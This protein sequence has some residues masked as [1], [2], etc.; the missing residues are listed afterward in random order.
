MKDYIK[1]KFQK[2]LNNS[3]IG[4]GDEKRKRNK[5]AKARNEKATRLQANAK[6]VIAN[7]SQLQPPFASQVLLSSSKLKSMDLLSEG[8]IE[9]FF[10]Q[11]GERCDPLEAFYLNDVPVV[12]SS[13]TYEKTMDLQ[14]NK[15]YGCYMNYQG[16]V[17]NRLASYRNY[18]DETFPD[19]KPIELWA[20]ESTGTTFNDENDGSWVRS[21]RLGVLRDGMI[22]SPKSST[23]F[24][25]AA[26][27]ADIATSQFTAALAVNPWFYKKLDGN[28]DYNALTY[29]GTPNSPISYYYE[30]TYRTWHGFSNI[31]T[32]QFASKINGP[33]QA[34]TVGF[35]CERDYIYR[36]SA[37][38]GAGIVSDP[39]NVF[40]GRGYRTAPKY[41]HS[42]YG[43]DSFLSGSKQNFNVS[44]ESFYTNEYTVDR[45]VKFKGSASYVGGINETGAAQ[46]AYCN[47]ALWMPLT[48]Y[49]KSDS[50]IDDFINFVA[51]PIVFMPSMFNSFASTL[52]ISAAQHNPIQA[53]FD[54]D[55]PVVPNSFFDDNNSAHP[56]VKHSNTQFIGNSNKSLNYT[57]AHQAL[58]WGDSPRHLVGVMRGD[59]PMKSF[60]S[61][62]P[63]S[64]E[65]EGL[66]EPI[67]EAITGKVKSLPSQ[68]LPYPELGWDGSTTGYLV[69]NADG[70]RSPQNFEAKTGAGGVQ[71]KLKIRRYLHSQVQAETSS[72]YAVTG[73][74]RWRMYGGEVWW[75][76]SGYGTD[77]G[78]GFTV[79]TDTTTYETSAIDGITINSDGKLSTDANAFFLGASGYHAGKGIDYTYQKK[80]G[81]AVNN[82]QESGFGVLLDYGQLVMTPDHI[83]LIGTEPPQFTVIDRSGANVNPITGNFEK[84]YTLEYALGG[85][86]YETNSPVTFD[87]VMPKVTGFNGISKNVNESMC[88][89]T[90]VSAGK[91]PPTV[92]YSSTYSNGNRVYTRASS[93]SEND[94]KFFPWNITGS[95]VA[96]PHNLALTEKK[97]STFQ[98]TFMW[99][100]YLGENCEGMGGGE[101]SADP[102]IS[103]GID[104]HYTD[105][106]EEEDGSAGGGDLFLRDRYMDNVFVTNQLDSVKAQDKLDR[107]KLHGYDLF[108]GTSD[109][110]IQYVHVANPKASIPTGEMVGKNLQVKLTSRS[111][112]L[113]NYTN[114]SIA[115][116]LGTDRM[117][118]VF[119]GDVDQIGKDVSYNAPLTTRNITEFK[120]DKE[121]FGPL[122]YLKSGEDGANIKLQTEKNIDF[123]GVYHLPLIHNYLHDQNPSTFSRSNAST[124]SHPTNGQ[125]NLATGVVGLSGYLL[126][127]QMTLFGQSGYATTSSDIEITGGGTGHDKYVDYAGWDLTPA[128]DSDETNHNHVVHRQE[129]DSVIINFAIDALG[130][131]QAFEDDGLGAT[132]ETDR[133]SVN[134]EVEVGFQDVS[135]EIYTPT[136]QRI[137]YEGRVD[138]VYRVDSE[139]IILPK[140]STIVESF[141]GETISSVANKHKRY[142]IIRKLDYETLSARIR[143]SI[144][145]VGISEVI[146][147]AFTYPGSAVAKINVDARQFQEI[148]KRTYNVRLKKVLIPSNYY[149]LDTA[150]KD[151]R[152]VEKESDVGTRVIYDG[153]WNGNFKLGWTDNPAWILY[154]LLINNRY[155]LGSRLDDLED[156]DIFNLYKIG[157]YCDAVNEEG[158]YLGIQDGIGGLEPR[159]SCN[160]LFNESINAFD[161]LQEISSIFNGRAFWSNGSIDFYSDRPSLTSAYFN[162]GNVFD[163]V[164]NYEDTSTASHFNVVEVIFQDKNDDFKRKIETVEDEEGIRKNGKLVRRTTGRGTTSRGQARRLA[165]YILYS[166]KLEREIVSFQAGT[167]SLMLNVG[168]VME[169]QDELKGF[170][171]DY[172]KIV[173]TERLDGKNFIHIE[174]TINSGSIITDASTDF[175]TGNEANQG[176]Y[177]PITGYF[178]QTPTSKDDLYDHLKTGGNITEKRIDSLFATDGSEV[179]KSNLE[180]AT[181]SQAVRDAGGKSLHDFN[182][183]EIY[184]FPIKSV[185][186]GVLDENYNTDGTFERYTSNGFDSDDDSLHMNIP[187]ASMSV[188]TKDV[189]QITEETIPQPPTKTNGSDA[190]RAVEAKITSDGVGAV[191]QLA[192]FNQRGDAETYTSYLDNKDGIV[193][194]IYYVPASNPIVGN[195]WHIGAGNSPDAG[196]SSQ[197]D[198]KD[199]YSNTGIYISGDVWARGTLLYGEKFGGKDK[200]AGDGTSAGG[201]A[202]FLTVLNS[203]EL[204]NSTQRVLSTSEGQAYYISEYTLRGSGSPVCSSIKL[205]IDMA[206]TPID[207]LHLVKHVPTGAFAN[208]DLENKTKQQYRVLS[209]K[210]SENNLYDIVGTEYNSSKFEFID[211]SDENFQ[212]SDTTGFNIGIPEH[213]VNLPTEPTS[214]T[215]TE[216]HAPDGTFNL[217]FV[218]NGDLNGTEKK[219]LLSVVFPNGVRQDKKVLKGDSDGS[220]FVTVESI[221]GLI[222]FGTY[223]V[224]VKSIE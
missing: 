98:G 23:N 172:A 9:G 33:G 112:D 103:D 125:G 153:S 93:Y 64:E 205:E 201:A 83:T 59:I 89:E 206:N 183:S 55:N 77:Y 85:E 90:D 160:I 71:I 152:F 1:K 129:V 181:S 212:V 3:I 69:F 82:H 142:A 185:G 40:C 191:P 7:F 32:G 45:P 110:G 19:K 141:P 195:Y 2:N 154:D 158:F 193:D 143:R 73:E 194:F 167:E 146:N 14:Y 95:D 102:N 148:P 162:N 63:G 122:H 107:A 113:F 116:S 79:E 119:D 180:E 41:Q 220:K 11:D 70:G 210:P 169:V 31:G 217:H 202:R 81:S 16:I 211:K 76:G 35:A 54:F 189:T 186:S 27:D 57:P 38:S 18:L 123:S 92:G 26:G 99:P 174:N 216:E 130:S 17:S 12:E 207:P 10:N 155:G 15:L 60:K 5:A 224:F 213:T 101:N 37:A 179:F 135:A 222:T 200:G 20:L 62:L 139:E 43:Q 42:F 25:I 80:V 78:A 149:P 53:P 203:S 164:F 67:I 50:D 196:E 140:F 6:E 118:D 157:R 100:V 127:S 111:P 163:G 133:L 30:G 176:I 114:T 105:Q 74:F 197:I 91:S 170:A 150:G 208:I 46:T 68:R 128:L 47:R 52:N 121:L 115:T 13:K 166:N 187:F 145:V 137:S 21:G 175:A 86:S 178:N 96:Y 151:K 88:I 136:K 49:M 138:S 24:A 58:L 104:R 126:N 22:I 72:G 168:D 109:G 66:K 108:S 56:F 8:P 120:V 94:R 159:F 147:Q 97:S 48:Q 165:K 171:I 215:H 144:S 39:T 190:T 34:Q 192:L 131:E 106:F 161:M 156:I 134:L 28:F 184:K 221:R 198:L 65:P 223:N 75:V 219:Y 4:H 61:F 218:I 173:K 209:I 177:L 51:R 87:Y 214:F 132:V 182:R 204:D 84:N 199:V 36:H 124:F 188:E 117:D 29:Y 44:D